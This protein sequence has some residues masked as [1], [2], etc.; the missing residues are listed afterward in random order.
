MIWDTVHKSPLSAR[1][2]EQ[3]YKHSFDHHKQTFYFGIASKVTSWKRHSPYIAFS[4]NCSKCWVQY[5]CVQIGAFPQLFSLGCDCQVLHQLQQI[6]AYCN[7]SIK[8]ELLTGANTRWLTSTKRV[9]RLLPVLTC[10][11]KKNLTLPFC[12]VLPPAPGKG[13]SLF[14]PKTSLFLGSL[15]TPCWFLFVPK[16]PSILR[17]PLP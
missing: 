12:L 10:Y 11:C 15:L 8:V 16:A 3:W 14:L 13:Y 7:G 2:A 9:K 6:W 5:R 1:R 4:C 17:V